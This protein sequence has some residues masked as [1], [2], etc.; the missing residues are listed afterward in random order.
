METISVAVVTIAIVNALA[1]NRRQEILCTN[2]DLSPISLRFP[3]CFEG[4]FTQVFTVL[5]DREPA[6]GLLA[7]A[8]KGS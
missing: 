5:K 4:S 1:S 3:R 7:I 8:A 6:F 2:A